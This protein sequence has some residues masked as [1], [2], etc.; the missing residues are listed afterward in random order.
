MEKKQYYKGILYII[1]SA[2]CFAIM[3]LCIRLSGDLP[4]IQ[5]SFFRNFVAAIFAAILLAKSRTTWLCRRENLGYML[6]RAGFGTAGILCN[7]YA[8]DH[9]L[10]AD[11]SMLNKLSPFF[12]VIF[13][14]FWLRESIDIKRILL[15]AG[16]F[17][18]S[19]LV[20]KPTG[21][22]LNLFPAMIGM[23]GGMAAGAAYTM[24]RKLGLRG[25]KGERIVFFFSAFSC[26][27]TLPFLLLQFHPMSARQVGILLLAGMAAAGGQFSITAAYCHAPAREI[28]IYDYSQIIFAALLGFFVF[29]Q[30]PDLLSF[31]GYGVICAAA[32]GMFFLG[33]EKR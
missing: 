12:A 16:A 20:I 7:Y 26:V 31:A 1:L 9:L 2:F 25:E 32:A 22:N 3:S 21:S 13:S 24:V 29:G 23:L 15:I 28:S 11:A 33:R 4:S 5:K 30:M 18:G 8:V 19:L 27:V 6:L 17:L 10:L 14:V